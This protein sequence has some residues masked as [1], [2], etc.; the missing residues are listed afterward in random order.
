MFEKDTFSKVTKGTDG[1]AGGSE[2]KTTGVKCK[3]EVY[4]W[5]T[6]ETW[7]GG[8]YDKTHDFKNRMMTDT[9]RVKSLLCRLR[10]PVPVYHDVSVLVLSQRTGR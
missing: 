9:T 6:Y 3:H 10:V 8:K 7:R 2:R 4:M 5:L 1:R